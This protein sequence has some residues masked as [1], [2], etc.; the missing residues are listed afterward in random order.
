M[1]I[2]REKETTGSDSTESPLSLDV[3]KNSEGV[4]NASDADTANTVFWLKLT[5]V[6]MIA[7]NLLFAVYALK[8]DRFVTQPPTA[9]SDSGNGTSSEPTESSQENLDNSPQ[10]ASDAPRTDPI[11]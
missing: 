8:S 4:P 2:S 10:E 6:C 11:P 1:G 3:P 5:I 7:L 9:E